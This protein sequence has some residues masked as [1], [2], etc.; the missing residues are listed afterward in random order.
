MMGMLD[1][2]IRKDGCWFRYRACAI[3]L[4]E[5]YVLFAGND[6]DDYYYSVGG[7]V[8]VGETAEEAVIREVLEETG[9]RYEVDRLAFVHE[10]FF[11]GSGSLAD[12][13]VCHELALYFLMKPRGTRELH[14]HGTT[15]GFEETMHWLPADNLRAYKA[16]PTFLAD[17]LPVPTGVTH[18]VTHEKKTDGLLRPKARD[19]AVIERACPEDEEAIFALYHS[20]L[21]MPYGTW[22]ENY[23]TRECVRE[24]LAHNDVFVIRGEAGRILAAIVIEKTEEF[25]ADVPWYPDVTRW[26]ALGRLGV[27][28]EVQGQGIARRMLQH[29]MDQAKAQGYEAV[30]F[31]V[32]AC[33]VPALHSYAKLGFD[34]CGKIELWEGEWY[35][36]QKRL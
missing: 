5:G 27:A 13:P 4:E 23:P 29:A 28:R 35:C 9:V 10:N 34:V 22:N 21:D 11:E 24:D 17:H 18:I 25:E 33:N 15:Q 32:A 14:P 16:F 26:C 12:W 19:K 30:R 3:I 2:G 7:G 8:H 6:A 1:C 36:Y 20:L 31:L